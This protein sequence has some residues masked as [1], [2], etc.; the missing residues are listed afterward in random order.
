ME[1][2]T[3]TLLGVCSPRVRLPKKTL[4]QRTSLVDLV[5]WTDGSLGHCQPKVPLLIF[6][7]AAFPVPAGPGFCNY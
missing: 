1:H 7:H 5:T 2:M 4:G 6:E 3:F